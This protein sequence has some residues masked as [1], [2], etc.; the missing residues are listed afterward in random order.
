ML[1]WVLSN[2]ATD[3]LVQKYKVI[4]IQNADYQLIVLDYKIN[5]LSTTLENEIAFQN[6]MT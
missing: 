4:G 5:L 2:V 6:K 1:G 3:A